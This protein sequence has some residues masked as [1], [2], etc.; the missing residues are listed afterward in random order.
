MTLR[1]GDQFI[2][3]SVGGVSRLAFKTNNLKRRSSQSFLMVDL[4]AKK[5][6]PDICMLFINFGTILIFCKHH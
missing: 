6:P 4:V 3:P 2:N 5:Y 1:T